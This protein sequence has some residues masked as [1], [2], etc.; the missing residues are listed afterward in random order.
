MLNFNNYSI[1]TKLIFVFIAFKVTLLLLI[2][3]VGFMSF[4]EV[5]ELLEEHSK[6]VVEKSNSSL[7]NTTNLAITNSIKALDQ[8]SQNAIEYKTH[9]IANK[10]AEFLK[11][12]D[13]DILF[14]SS[15]QISQQ[16]LEKFYSQKNRNIYIPMEYRYDESTQQWIPKKIQTIYTG[17]ETSDLKDNSRE[18]HKINPKMLSKKMIPIYKEVAYYNLEG[19]EIYKVSSIQSKLKNIS[20]K[21]NTYINSETYYEKAKK[22][23]KGEIYVSKVIGAYVPSKIIGS[24][25]STKAKKAN[26][27]FDPK[28]YAYAG[29]ENPL[30]RKFEG[31]IRFVTPVYRKNE[32]KGYL[33]F[34]LDHHH[35][36]DFTDFVDPLHAEPLEISDASEGNYAFMWDSD[37]KSI[38]HP[39]DYFIVGYDHKTGE[40]VPGWIDSK[41]ASQFKKS[42][43]ENL[44]SFLKQM[45]TFLH[46]SLTKKPNITQ[47]KTGKI[48]LDC[49]YLNF[50]PQCQGWRQL[51]NEGGYG[52]FIIF[53]SN[54]W[55]LTTAA[56][57]PYYTGQYKNSKRGFG[58]VTIG[59][60]V[61]EFHKVAIR[62]QK[63]I[64]KILLNEEI[65]IKNH[66][67][68]IT[69]NIF[70][71][72]KRQLLI[73]I[74]LAIS[75][76]IFMLYIA[77]FISNNI[78]K[79]INS[80]IIGTQ[81][82]KDND[83]NYKLKIIEHDE[84]GKLKSSFNEMAESISTL[85]GNLKQKLYTD[86]L[87]KLK[88][89]NSLLRDLK[90]NHN[91]TIFILDIDQFKNINGYY[92]IEA[93]NF[94]LKRFA[95]LLKEFS[96]NRNIEVYRIGSDEYLLLKDNKI[97]QNMNESLI[98]ELKTVIQNENF[99]NE[100]LHINT[101][102]DFTCGI[103]S[104]ND[105]LLEKANLALN[106]A[107]R[108]KVSYMT[109]SSTNPK[110]N[111]LKENILWKEKIIY[112]IAHDNVVPFFQEIVDVK[113]NKN[114]KYEALIRIIDETN[115]ISPYLFLDTAKE[116]KLYPELTKIM[117]EKTFKIFSKND[118]KLSINL[119]VNDITNASTTE[120]IHK[121]IKEYK[122]KDK[123]IFELLESEEIGNFN[124]VM[125][126]I[127]EMRELGVKFAI[128]DFGSG[129]SNFSYLLQI[130]PDY[131]KI[132]GSIIKNL[133]ANSNEYHII[134]AIV[135]F[136]KS[137][138]IKI[139]AE[140][141]SSQ[142][143]IEVLKNFD[144][145][146]MQGFH[147]SEP[148]P[149]LN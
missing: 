137:L 95:I 67:F 88:N 7:E 28:K 127:K 16:I 35:I 18:F 134:S 106:E 79:R 71:T 94:I 101:T 45:P 129:Y 107:K 72:I 68:K 149:R 102:I 21:T 23:K 55:K 98:K 90:H 26:I 50:A 91:T 44:N 100:N 20:I 64:N 144:I 73:L 105:N 56:T 84:I 112:A 61:K 140:H 81:R 132:D 116:T 109:Y 49:R 130:Q 82:I 119:S 141:V 24:F 146:Y 122:M 133:T 111:K 110:M 47:I 92:G 10:V 99:K 33:S 15:Q 13:E 8:K 126:F 17:H 128:D 96:K 123:V 87:T 39:R 31:I 117:I 57:I 14:L 145:D 22:L 125:P 54:V 46:Q 41:M 34:A 25:T 19:K 37:F 104:G 62:T 77:I 143:I 76:I 2:F 78:S 124:E 53:W 43:I 131:I 103:S 4:T 60:N 52:S 58:F 120:F 83:F 6:Q 139:V 142:E 85:T 136:A 59:A 115:I 113:D 135:L 32:L 30:G 74:I 66:I 97:S 36:M 89:R 114:K 9:A 51:T 38:S 29:K 63:N 1:K 118:M 138:G 86:E 65:N 80:I 75:F 5:K 70:N 69:E 108:K 121:K 48:P 148:S 12:R 93:G 42:N 27:K 3:S 40:M 147:F 11:Q